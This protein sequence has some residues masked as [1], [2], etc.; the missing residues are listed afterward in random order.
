MTEVL[1]QV[2]ERSRRQVLAAEFPADEAHDELARGPQTGCRHIGLE[3][4]E[5][6]GRVGQQEALAPIEPQQ[7][8]V[9]VLRS[10]AGG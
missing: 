6:R 10:R 3:D 8:R 2:T 9:P 1:L 7:I 5:E 4:C